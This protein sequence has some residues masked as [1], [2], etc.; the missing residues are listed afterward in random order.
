MK[1]IL[2]KKGEIQ[3]MPLLLG[4]VG[5]VFAIIM[6]KR[7][8]AGFLYTAITSLITGGACYFIGYLAANK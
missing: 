1:N 7:M 3:P 8:G 6:A 2:D 5:A 4:I